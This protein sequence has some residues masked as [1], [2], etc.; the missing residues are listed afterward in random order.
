MELKKFLSRFLKQRKID[1]SEKDAQFHKEIS[2]LLGSEIVD[3][4]FYKL[5]FS[6]KNQSKKVDDRYN[7]YERL[8]FLGDSVLGTIISCYTF[9]NYPSANEGFLTQL[10]SKIVNRKNLNKIGNELGLK[11]L[12]RNI[13]PQT[14]AL[15]EN[16]SGNLF[17]AFIGA[18]YLDLGY[19]KCKEIVLQKLL[20][21]A[22]INGLEKKI[23]SYKSILL[24]W[25][26]KNKKTIEYATTEE[27]QNHKSF[28][29]RSEVIINNKSVSNATDS[30]K[31]KAEEKAA[32]RAFYILNKRERILE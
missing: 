8:E 12:I 22:I 9:H 20:T 3:I 32:Q 28:V 15:S 13:N 10:K 30:S 31:K 27:Q 1:I 11:K 24:E 6:L 2:S 18:I 4:N 14:T 17:E 5:A 26:Q 19:D 23:I 21:P 7:N 16:L 29:F 25:G